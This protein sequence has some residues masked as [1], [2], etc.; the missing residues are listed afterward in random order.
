MQS[1]YWEIEETR[2][3]D[4]VFVK[5]FSKK[6]KR[7]KQSERTW[8]NFKA[9]YDLHESIDLYFF[10]IVSG[11]SSDLILPFSPTTKVL[12]LLINSKQLKHEVY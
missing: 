4:W 10:L 7:K 9:F 2:V 1:N 5:E 3:R 6:R 11:L 12:Q 8:K